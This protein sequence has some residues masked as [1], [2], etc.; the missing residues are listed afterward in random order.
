MDHTDAG[1]PLCPFIER[2]RREAARANLHYGSPWPDSKVAVTGS[3]R[4]D[5]TSTSPA[6]DDDA[7]KA[8]PATRVACLRADT[9]F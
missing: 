5:L 8:L 9:L 6:A 3:A 2:R 7:L 1:Q 4:S